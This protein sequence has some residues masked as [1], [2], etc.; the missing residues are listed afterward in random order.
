MNMQFTEQQAALINLNLSW[1]FVA[2]HFNDPYDAIDA[3]SNP[4]YSEGNMN[5]FRK[6]KKKYEATYDCHL[7]IDNN[8]SMTWGTEAYGMFSNLRDVLS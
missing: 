2:A 5:D 7:T 4:E 6:A 8:Y 1:S 3:Y